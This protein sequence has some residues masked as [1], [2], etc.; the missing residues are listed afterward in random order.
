MNTPVLDKFIKGWIQLFTRSPKT[1]LAWKMSTNLQVPLYSTTKWWSKWDVITQLLKSF[2]NVDAFR[3]KSDLPPSKV[4]LQE[5]IN[6]PP[7]NYKLQMDIAITVDAMEVLVKATY[8]GKK[9]KLPD[10]V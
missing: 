5:I 7:N 1:K 2:D 9:F 4:K 6:D 10:S 8:T 3:R